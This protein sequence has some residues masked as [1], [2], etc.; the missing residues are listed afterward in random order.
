[1]VCDVHTSLHHL[2]HHI[3]TIAQVVVGCWYNYNILDSN[4]VSSNRS[5]DDSFLK[6]YLHQDSTNHIIISDVM[7][8]YLGKGGTWHESLNTCID[9]YLMTNKVLIIIII[10]I[11][12]SKHVLKIIYLLIM[13]HHII[14]NFNY[15]H[16]FFILPLNYNQRITFESPTLNAGECMLVVSCERWERPWYHTNILIL[17]KKN[18]FNILIMYWLLETAKLIILACYM[19]IDLF[20]N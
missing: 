1:M 14:C 5:F 2:P 15:F 16:L 17:D 19:M 18:W 6:I 10:I 13:I 4:P 8:E 9:W 3:A 11:I 20:G 7:S 12:N